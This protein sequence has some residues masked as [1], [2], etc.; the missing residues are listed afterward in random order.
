M[1]ADIRIEAPA[2]INLTLEVV[3][4]LPSG[5]HMIRSVIVRLPRLLDVVHVAIDRESDGITITT[6]SHDIPLDQGNICHRIASL[7]LHEINERAHVRI[8]IDKNVPIVAGMGGGSSDAA[9]VLLA[10]N[11]YYEYP[12]SQSELTSLALDIGRDIPFFLS[13]APA[14]MVSATGENVRAITGPS[15]LHTLIVNPRVAVST[16]EAYEALSRELWF[17]DHHMRGDRSSAMA[18]A[19]EADDLTAIAATLYND[20][21]LIVERTLPIVKEIRQALVALGAK[22]A[23]MSGSGPTVFGL[24]ASEESLEAAQSALSAHYA[25]FVVVRA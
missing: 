19:C 5:Y 6:N 1:T 8:G 3:G 11:R 22:G 13:G 25:S 7:Y 21:E 20:F 23:L 16:K 12:L 17:M 10:L 24:F 14:C 2:K 4:R 18:C 9:A 15:R